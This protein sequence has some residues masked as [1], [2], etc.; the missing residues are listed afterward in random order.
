MKYV[1]DVDGTRHELSLEEGGVR[2]GDTLLPAHLE[3]VQGTPVQVLRLGGEVHRVAYKRGE[4]RGAYTLWIDGHRLTVDALDERTRT[5]RD[6]TAATAGV[7]GP[8]PL[9]APMPGLIV[10]VYVKV[11]DQVDAGQGLVAM[12]AMK[13][14]NEL[15]APSAGRVKSIPVALG[16]AVEKGAVL[17]ELE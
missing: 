9:L 2:F 17:V 3:Q 10:K 16:A 5:I 13:M 1:V 14:E 15:R 4:H 8:K 11:G 12:E 7:Q 6:L